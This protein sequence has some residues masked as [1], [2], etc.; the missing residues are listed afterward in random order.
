MIQGLCEEGLLDE[1]KELFVKMEKNSGLPNDVNYNTIIGGFLGQQKCYEV[2]VLLEKMLQKG[3]SPDASTSS[4]I[5]DLISTRG[6]D[7]TL[8]DVIKKFFPKDSHGMHEIEFFCEGLKFYISAYFLSNLGPMR[9]SDTCRDCILG[10]WLSIAKLGRSSGCRRLN[11]SGILA[12]GVGG[13]TT[14]VINWIGYNNGCLCKDINVDDALSLLV[15]MIQQDVALDVITYSTLIHGL[16][17]LG[18]WEEAK[19]MLRDIIDKNVFPDVLTF[20][21]L[22]DALC[23]E[24]MAKEI[25]VVL[26]VMVQR[27]VG[28]NAV[29]YGTLMDGYVGQ[30]SLL[31]KDINVD[32]ALS[33]LVEMIQQDVA[34]DVITYSTLIH[35]LCNLGR[36]EEAKRMLRDM[37]DKN[38]FPDVLTFTT[39][40]DALCKEG[41]AKETEV[42]LEVMVQRGVGPNAVKYGTLMDGYC[43]LGHMDRAIEVFHSMVDK[44]IK[45]STLSYNIL[46][47]G[48]CKN[49]KFEEAINLFCEMPCKGLKPTIDT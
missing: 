20:T 39:L 46:I 12:C 2:L 15:E 28:P 7:P 30:S 11:V 19:R 3:F 41:M 23:K 31:C 37:I 49:M 42:V 8:Q 44:G 34:L 27:G 4:L 6:Q 40:I 24:G 43:L 17:N 18:R 47:N 14:A 1:A 35:G 9:T 33:L 38:V 25:E 13:D 22:I 29:K 36:W 21:T 10:Q 26:E 48:C 32:D 45:P 5:V 16:C